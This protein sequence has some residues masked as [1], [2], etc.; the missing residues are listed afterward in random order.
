MTYA[1]LFKKLKAIYVEK[2]AAY[3][4]NG[5]ETFKEFGIVSYL[6]RISDKIKR[7]ESLTRDNVDDY[8]E[9]IED[10]ILDTI[11]YCIMCIGEIIGKVTSNISEEEISN[12]DMTIALYNILIE[13]EYREFNLK[14]TLDDPRKAIIDAYKENK[15]YDEVRLILL[16]IIDNFVEKAMAL[17]NKGE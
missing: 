5:H 2:N 8:G 16:S 12:V 13:N 7:Y 11:N 10:T 15:T 4:N 14:N 1:D 6:I 9:S 17:Y 3:G